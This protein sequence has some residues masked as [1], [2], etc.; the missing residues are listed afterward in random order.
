MHEF[1]AGQVH[2]TGCP[3]PSKAAKTND[4]A[5]DSRLGLEPAFCQQPGHGLADGADHRLGMRLR[6]SN[7]PQFIGRGQGIELPS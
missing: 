5:A 1:F 7:G 3:P 4:R 2:W 6:D